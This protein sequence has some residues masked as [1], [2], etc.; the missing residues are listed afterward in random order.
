[1]E[2]LARINETVTGGSEAIDGILN[3]SIERLGST[4]TDQSFSRWPP[5]S[6]RARN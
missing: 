6:A 1:M 2:S 3:S 5:P 4:L